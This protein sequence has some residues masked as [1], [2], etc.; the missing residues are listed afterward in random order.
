MFKLKP[1]V[2]PRG[3]RLHHPGDSSPRSIPFLLYSS[4]T[5]SLVFLSL[6]TNELIITPI[7]AQVVTATQLAPSKPSMASATS[8]PTLVPSPT[9][10]A[11]AEPL[12]ASDVLP[13]IAEREPIKSYITTIFGPNARTAIAIASAESGKVDPKT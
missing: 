9:P 3:C 8:M 4:V 12:E 11:S 2:G 1:S 5:I 13:L 6:M 10:P 7:Q